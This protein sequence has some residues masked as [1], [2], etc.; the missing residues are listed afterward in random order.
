MQKIT[1][2]ENAEFTAAFNTEP[3]QHR[4]RVTVVMDGGERFVAET[5]GDE[6]DISGAVSDATIEEKFRGLTEDVL[7]AKRVRETLARL[8]HLEEM[9]STAEIPRAFVIT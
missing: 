9:E 2:D 7:G 4:A 1:V 6:D 5:G 3:Q 8:W